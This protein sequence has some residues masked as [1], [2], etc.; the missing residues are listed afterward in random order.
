MK[1]LALIL[2]SCLTLP[3][4]AFEVDGRTVTFT[5]ADIQ[6]CQEGG[7]CVFVS[8]KALVEMIEKS[9]STASSCSDRA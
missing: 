6:A 9:R 1:R 4:P 7:G 8:R 3:A 5:D 2:L